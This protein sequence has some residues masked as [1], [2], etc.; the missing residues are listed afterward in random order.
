MSMDK[1]RRLAYLRALQGRVADEIDA[2]EYQL[3]KPRRQPLPLHYQTITEHERDDFLA[4]IAATERCRQAR[5]D[6]PRYRTRVQ[7]P[8][9][10]SVS[11]DNEASPQ[12]ALTPAGSDHHSLLENER[13]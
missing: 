10:D 2:L 8:R 11:W 1:R 9:P 12:G 13:G 3:G 5:S 4:V 6:G 7:N